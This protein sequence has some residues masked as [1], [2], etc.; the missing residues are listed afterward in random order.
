MFIHLFLNLIWKAFKVWKDI[1]NDTGRNISPDIITLTNVIGAL[2]RE[3]VSQERMDE[4]FSDAVKRSLV[5]KEDSLDTT[6][7]VD[8]SGM[9]LSVARAACRFVIK[10]AYERVRN[11]GEKIQE[12]IFITGCKTHYTG[13]LE[14]QRR[15]SLE[16]DDLYAYDFEPN[17]SRGGIREYIQNSLR[18]DF[19]PPLLTRVPQNSLGSIIISKEC[20]QRWIQE[21]DT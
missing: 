10:R 5:L 8:L 14:K 2:D 21:Q 19:T 16:E 17:E 6:W 15:R 20:V 18:N 13:L 4:V 9:S 3:S 7:E 1:C 12:L 11:D